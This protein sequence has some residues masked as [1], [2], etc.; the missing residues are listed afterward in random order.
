MSDEQLIFMLRKVDPRIAPYSERPVYSSPHVP[1]LKPGDPVYSWYYD[2]GGSRHVVVS[3]EPNDSSQSK[4]RVVTV[5]A[6][7]CEHCC[8]RPK[9][10][11]PGLDAAWFIPAAIVEEAKLVMATKGIQ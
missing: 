6:E 9:R 5:P 2:E 1:D 10:L 4:V 3:V 11:P 7:A 8:V